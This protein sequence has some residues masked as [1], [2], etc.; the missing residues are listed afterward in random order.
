MMSM[1][2]STAG[3]LCSGSPI[4]MY[5]MFLRR[6]PAG[7]GGMCACPHHVRLRA[8]P[9]DGSHV[10]EGKKEGGQFEDHQRPWSEEVVA[11]AA[12]L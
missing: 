11:A 8:G 4:P 9:V 7:G 12:W 3:R 2:G 10:E 1:E 5:T 6:E